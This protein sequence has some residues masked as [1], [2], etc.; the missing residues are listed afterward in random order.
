VPTKGEAPPLIEMVGVIKRELGLEGTLAEVVAEAC[1]QLG[2]STEGKT[3][4][5]QA[6]LCWRSLV[7]C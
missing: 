6:T 2:V 5:E 4:A 3:L 1:K 7:G